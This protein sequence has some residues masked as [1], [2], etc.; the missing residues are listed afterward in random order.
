MEWSEETKGFLKGMGMGMD[1]RDDVRKEKEELDEDDIAREEEVM[2]EIAQNESFATQ[3]MPNVNSIREKHNTGPKGVLADYNE[4]RER[5]IREN[6][7]KVAAQ[8]AEMERKALRSKYEK[9]MDAQQDD[10][11]DL[12]DSDDEFFQDWKA[13]ILHLYFIL[14]NALCRGSKRRY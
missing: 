3:G 6:R 1:D 7:E 9:P 2:R 4:W 5:T 10:D 11:D 13:G 14:S 12:D 8:Y